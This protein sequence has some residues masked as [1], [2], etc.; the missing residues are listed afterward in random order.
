MQGS[1]TDATVEDQDYRRRI[2]QMLAVHLPDADVYDPR[3]SH[4]DSVDYGDEKG[5]RV[6]FN[7]N[8][9]CAQVDVVLAFVPRAS[10][11]T[12]IEMWEAHQHGRAVIAI[13]PLVH[14]WTIRFLCH[15]VYPSIEEFERALA[16]G[17]LARLLAEI[18]NP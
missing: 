16:D 18:L 1:R 6:F 4:A 11:G 2:T 9:L 3:A 15:Q 10:M 17:T 7:H 8:R 13:T 5:R 14:N 12:A